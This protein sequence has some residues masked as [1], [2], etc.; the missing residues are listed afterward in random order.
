VNIQSAFG[1]KHAVVV[2]NDASDASLERAVRQSEALAKLAPDDPES[3][4]P[5]G[6]QQYENVTT[7]FDSTGNLGPDGRAHGACAFIENSQRAISKP[8]CRGIL[9]WG[10]QQRACRASGIRLSLS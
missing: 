9:R 7:Y 6:P 5:L 4:P 1:P 2:T 8:C 10:G 3:M